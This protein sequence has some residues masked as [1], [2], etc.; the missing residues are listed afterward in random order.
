M[1]HEAILTAQ[2]K[3]G[4]KV[5]TGEEFQWGMDHLNITEER[6]KEIGAEGLMQPMHNTC[7]DHEGGGKVFYQQWNG[8]KWVS[9]GEVMTPMRKFVREKIEQ[10][11]AK[12]AKEKGITPRDCD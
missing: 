4:A 6:I 1:N 2:K 12:Y 10:S 3:F 8:E 9:T 11:A 5:L 7:S